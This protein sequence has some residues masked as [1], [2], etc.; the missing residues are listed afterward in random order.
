MINKFDGNEDDLK[1]LLDTFDQ[2]KMLY[3][4]SRNLFDLA[5]DLQNYYHRNHR[6]EE[7]VLLWISEYE[8]NCES[9]GFNDPRTQ[10]VL[11][12][13]REINFDSI[14]KDTYNHIYDILYRDFAAQYGKN[15]EKFQKEICFLTR[16]S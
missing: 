4:D 1:Q 7:E 12:M 13:I 9:F 2:M 16:S 3:P 14:S 10:R 8:R 11:G 5:I 6:F 15:S